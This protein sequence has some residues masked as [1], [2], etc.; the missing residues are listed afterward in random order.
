MPLG[1]AETLVVNLT[2]R[3]SERLEA[4]CE[5]TGYNKT[6]TVNRAIIIADYVEQM[7]RKGGQILVRDLETSDLQE[8]KIF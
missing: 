6:D 7:L 4:T 3:A 2:E 5:L 1:I 8:L